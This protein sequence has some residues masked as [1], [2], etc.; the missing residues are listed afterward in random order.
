MNHDLAEAIA[1]AHPRPGTVLAAQGPVVRLSLADA[2]VGEQVRVDDAL[3]EVIGFR[4][5]EALALPLTPI[6]VLQSGAPVARVTKETRICAGDAVI[7]RVLDGL[8]R[9]MDGGEPLPPPNWPVQRRAPD[10]L[11]RQP[12]STPMP[13]GVRV[14]DG[15]CTVGRGQRLGLEAGPAAGKST[16]LRQIAAQAEVDRVVIALIGERGREVGDFIRRL[17]PAARARTVI[18]VARA[19]DPPLA[20]L[21]AAETATA[22]AER[23]RTEGRDTL[24]LV[25]SLT[26]VARAIRTVGVAAGEP[27]T[28]RGF[29]VS[30]APTIAGLLERAAND[31]RGTLTAVYTVLVEGDVRDDPVA[32]EARALLDGHLV[33][34]PILAGAGHFPAVRVT[35][36][37]SR[38]MTD[39]VS[40]AHVEAAA[41]LRGWLAA[42][43]RQ[44]DLIAVGAYRAGA[45]PAADAALARAKE[46]DVF[47][48]QGS[49]D[50]TPF[51]KT[52]E[53]L[54]HLV[55]K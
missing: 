40:P 47:L 6:G 42:R 26:R 49:A 12:V 52:Y 32:E 36:S 14:I 16:L 7:G 38:C 8:G 37:V 3:L 43:D 27:V 21:R 55:R 24:L 35:A 23:F 51:E 50:V 25:D 45:D 13:L 44:A 17:S 30:L 1:A 28:R 33:L 46:I 31:T 53:A 19:D 18:V 4:G 11:M 34:D 48:R 54:M 10:P 2:V 39:L 20:W 5:T 41:R 9:R 29:P 15:L 22:L